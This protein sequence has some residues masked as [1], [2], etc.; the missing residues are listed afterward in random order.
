MLGDT[1]ELP[2]TKDLF[3]LPS[4]FDE[5]LK[6]RGLECSNRELVKDLMVKFLGVSDADDVVIKLTGGY[7]TIHDSALT[8][9][10]SIFD[11]GF[12]DELSANGITVKLPPFIYEKEGKL[13]GVGVLAINGRD[14]LL[15]SRYV[16]L[17]IE[18]RDD[19]DHWSKLRDVG[20]GKYSTSFYH[21]VS[22]ASSENLKRI[23]E[24]ALTQPVK[25]TV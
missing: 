2:S 12:V 25:Q 1:K 19:M 4:E 6:K 17:G 13:I 18:E 7:D 23:V 3:S 8:V 11:K 10:R 21:Q 22:D 9:G 5:Y 14:K 16:W 20:G 15:L 24:E